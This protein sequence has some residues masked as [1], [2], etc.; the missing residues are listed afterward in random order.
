[1][2]RGT[3]SSSST[4]SSPDRTTPP[5]GWK[6]HLDVEHSGGRGS[7]PTGWLL[8]LLGLW[9]TAAGIFVTWGLAK[10]WF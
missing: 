3:L 9:L 10:G 4:R 8:W 2:S 6:L 5:R 1:M 7:P